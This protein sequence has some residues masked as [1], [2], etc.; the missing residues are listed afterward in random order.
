MALS[1]DKHRAYIPIPAL[2]AKAGGSGYQGLSQKRKKGGKPLNTL[3]ETPNP[4]DLKRKTKPVMTTRA[5]LPVSGRLS[6]YE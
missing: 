5:V 3:T 4:H 6:Q 2:E 1:R